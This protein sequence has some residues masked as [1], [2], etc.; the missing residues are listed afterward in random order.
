MIK[1]SCFLCTTSDCLIK[2]HC[3]PK[4]LLTIDQRKNQ[5]LIKQNQHLIYEGDAVLGIYFIQKGK[6]KVFSTDFEE[7]RQFIRFAKEGHLLGH[8]G[9]NIDD[10]YPIN[11]VAL[12]DSVV[13]FIENTQVDH[14]FKNNRNF[15]YGL[16][17]FYSNEFRKLE[18]RIK[19]IPRMNVR[20]KVAEALLMI[21]DNFGLNNQNELNII[22]SRKT[23]ANIA[24]TNAETVSRLLSDFETNGFI[25]KN[26]RKITIL[27][28][29]GLNNI[30]NGNHTTE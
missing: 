8:R 4:G 22:L 18:S 12:Q 25:V 16:M 5:I 27:Q 17:M 26:S 2:K 19:N 20:E 11:V 29:D 21:Y 7:H 13:C 10:V 24:G 6:M 14:L 9:L 1:T 15:A 23:I 28:L 3:S 30:I